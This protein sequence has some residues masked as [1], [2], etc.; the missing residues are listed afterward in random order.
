MTGLLLPRR[1][2]GRPTE[3]SAAMYLVEKGRFCE[4]ILEINSRLDF[5][6]GSRGWGYILENKRMID[7]SDLDTAQALV[8]NCRKDGSLPL[9]ICSEDLKRATDGIEQLDP[10]DPEDEYRWLEDY[11]RRHHKSYSPV[12]FWEDLDFYIETAVEK[13]DLKS[14][15][16]KVSNEFHIPITNLGG[17][18]D[19]N[20]RASI[21]R[22]FKARE[23]EGK[24]CLLLYCGDHDPGGL[25]ISDFIRDNFRE[26]EGAVGWSSR[27]MIVDRF[28]LE[29][30]FIEKHGLTW[31][32]NLETSNGKYPLN[33]PHHRDHDK[34]YVQSYLKKFGVRKVEANALVAQ[35]EIGRALYRD[36]I[37]RWGSPTIDDAV[38]RY[39]ERLAA[40]Q[41]ALREL[42]EGRLLR[43]AR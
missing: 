25:Q 2:R 18:S 22:R 41:K 21:M 5:A 16:A 4:T 38:R 36:T 6:V 26:L 23:A 43:G 11:L 12:D 31:I 7:K 20:A 35:P 29:Y 42:I 15:F 30:D 37:L 14:L 8:N 10:S 3:A 9:D 24:T 32:D 1:T 27:N 40:K 33:D 28:G 19:L 39:K 17:W 34:P 13:S